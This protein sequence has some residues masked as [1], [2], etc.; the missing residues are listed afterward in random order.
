[1]TL[2]TDWKLP[3]TAMDLGGV[4]CEPWANPDN[5]LLEDA[6]NA[7]CPV[8]KMDDSC[9]LVLYNYGF[10]TTDVPENATITGVEV[11]VKRCADSATAVF[12]N[13]IYLKIEET[14]ISPPGD[15]LG[16]IVPW[17]QMLDW[18]VYGALANLW[19]IPE[20][21]G[22]IVRSEWFGNYLKV[23]NSSGDSNYGA[24]VDVTKIRVFYTVPEV[25]V[26]KGIPLSKRI[27]FPSQ[28]I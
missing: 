16:V 17:P 24:Y 27:S 8:P 21:D 18:A 3:G 1:M 11:S 2:V 22:D 20:L 10:T 25:A 7:S 13:G 19:G 14:E 4:G 28:G 9:F 15:N 26:K 6:Q 5:A 23:A 12:D